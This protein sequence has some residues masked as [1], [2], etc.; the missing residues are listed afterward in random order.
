MFIP[1]EAI[2]LRIRGGRV[3][4]V[5]W[6]LPQL[7]AFA[8]F[9]GTKKSLYLNDAHS[10]AVM[11]DLINR[12][13]LFVAERD[14]GSPVGFIA[15]FLGVHPFNPEIKLLTESFWWVD[16][17]FRGSRAAILLLEEFTNWGK[18]NVDW[19]TFALEAKSPVT[20]RC[21]TRRGFQ[22]QERSFLME[23]H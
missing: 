22:L 6:L 10:T 15:G 17:Q 19:I 12:H 9:F 8:Q 7:K 1:A 18:A 13:V 11:L 4:D 14:D 3:D 20:E 16:P 23:V 2:P 21:L 5:Q